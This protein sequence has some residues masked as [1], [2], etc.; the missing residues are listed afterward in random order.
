MAV[1]LFHWPAL[2]ADLRVQARANARAITA[3]WDSPA[4]LKMTV[5]AGTTEARISEF[6]KNFHTRLLSA[7]P[8]L[9]FVPG[10]VLAG[11]GFEILFAEEAGSPTPGRVV[12]RGG[13]QSLQL[14]IH[15][16]PGYPFSHPAVQEAAAEVTDNVVATLAR[17]LLLPLAREVAGEKGLGPKTFRLHAARGRWGSCSSRGVIN[18]N[19][20]CIFMP[21]D[22]QRFIILHELTHLTH[23]NHSAAF[24]RLL[25]QYAEGREREFIVRLRAFRMPY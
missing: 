2:D 19:P 24:H 23:M 1:S 13:A 15:T 4:V 10:M 22:M 16:G 11:P 5:P 20:K 7:R 8:A 21:V 9:K 25:D 6:L 12:A 3:R 14:T 18:L 17:R